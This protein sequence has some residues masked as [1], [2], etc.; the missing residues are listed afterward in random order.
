MMPAVPVDVALE[1]GS[2]RVFAIALDWP[3][4]ARSGKTEDEALEAL[5]A[6]ADRYGPIAEAAGHALPARAATSLRVVETVKGDATTD[7]GAPHVVVDAD[8]AKTTKAQGARLVA[9]VQAAWDAFDA[10]AAAAPRSLRKG[11]RGGGRDTSKIVEHVVGNEPAYFG[12]VGITLPKPKPEDP[13]AWRRAAF[14]ELLAQPSDGTPPKEGGW[15]VR[16]VARRVAWH[17]LD[18]VWEIEDRS[19]P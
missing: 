13:V 3:G 11:P 10:A 2:K 14:L 6:Y 16:Y 7:F 4:W 17:A 1:V 8:R 18:H 15:P 19:D 5:A 9:F 12:K